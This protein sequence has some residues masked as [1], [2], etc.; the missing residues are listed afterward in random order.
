IISHSLSH[1]GDIRALQQRAPA[2]MPDMFRDKVFISSLPRGVALVFDQSTENKRGFITQIRPRLSQHGG[3]DRL[4]SLFE[5][6]RLMIP[7]GVPEESDL[8]WDLDDIA[9]E[10]AGELTEELSEVP[11]PPL[12]LSKE[13]WNTL[14]DW[15]Q[16]YIR[17]LFERERQDFSITDEPA[18]RATE[19]ATEQESEAIPQVIEPSIASVDAQ[20][21][22]S[23]KVRVR[24]FGPLSPSVLLKA[25]TRKILY[26][27]QPHRFLFT[28]GPFFRDTIPVQ[29]QDIAPS[30]LVEW[31][32]S[33]LVSAGLAI[34]KLED[35][36]EIT[37][38]MF[39]K[40]G[41]RGV[42]ATGVSG[43]I[44]CTP[45]VIVG[46]NRAT[47]VQMVDKIRMALS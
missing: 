45:V 27:K 36:D 35:D 34:E 37:F 9:S 24:Q 31:L 5:A 32:A 8:E 11:R 47:V 14:D 21:I 39:S 6:A 15:I 30:D 4:S 25:I 43:S 44:V 2:V 18:P 41:L 7:K 3:T 10:P 42:F 46:N 28:T 13:D 40:N 38:V 22:D 23:S 17:V 26:S 16:E 19:P 12:K 1:D 20:V 29:I 33:G